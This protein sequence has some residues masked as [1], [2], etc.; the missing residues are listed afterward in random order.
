MTRYS[1]SGIP[2]H[3]FVIREF[4]RI[5]PFAVPMFIWAIFA[6]RTNRSITAEQEANSKFLTRVKLWEDFHI[7]HLKKAHEANCP[8]CKSK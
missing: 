8:D 7:E 6:A 2:L 5:A 1:F 3:R 4:P